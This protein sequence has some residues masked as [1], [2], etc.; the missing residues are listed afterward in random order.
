MFRK[1]NLFWLSYFC[2]FLVLT[3]RETIIFFDHE[4]SQ[5]LYFYILCSFNNLFFFAYFL[6]LLQTLVTA[7][8]LIPLFLY[9]FHIR[10]LPAALWQ[11]LLIA[12][13]IL[14]I[15]GHPYELNALVGLSKTSPRIGLLVFSLTAVMYLPSYL[16]CLKYAFF[17]NEFFKT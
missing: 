12:R 4:S 1:L 7:V 2:I 11:H 3:I 8:H 6:S 15:A 13:L 17:Q 9:V 16:A 5:F 10:F 14:E